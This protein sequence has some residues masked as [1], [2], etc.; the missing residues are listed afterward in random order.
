M[1]YDEVDDDNPQPG[2]AVAAALGEIL[3]GLG[4]EVGSVEDG[5]DHGWHLDFRYRSARPTLEVTAIDGVVVQVHGVRSARQWLR[6]AKAATPD[7]V[8][9][10][11]Q[12]SEA[13]HADE[14][15]HD[16]G[17]FTQE[18]L[19]SREAGASTPVGPYSKAP[20]VRYFGSMGPVAPDPEEAI[21]EVDR[22]ASPTGWADLSPHP[23]RRWAARLF[24]FWVTT[25]SVFLLLLLPM[26]LLDPKLEVMVVPIVL[27]A[28]VFLLS[29]LRGLATAAVNALLLSRFS[30]TPGKWLG[31]VRIVRK[32]GAPLGFRVAFAREVDV[33]LRGCGLYI[34]LVA[35]VLIGYGFFQLR[36]RGVAPWDESR[37]LVAVQRGNS[38]GQAALVVTAVIPPIL[39]LAILGFM[40]EAMKAER[41]AG[42]G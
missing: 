18:E 2:G 23:I 26:I 32:D 6:T 30:T 33:W 11:L 31:G 15:F 19:T 7:D 12:L 41:L 13:I 4:C 8:E 9:I 3:R 39:I 1:P 16:L 34:P 38:L 21:S 24:D 42:V 29:P 27:I 17:W 25:G 36:A 28:A 35:Q 22:C 40:A 20:C 14:R 37:G 5:G 10:L